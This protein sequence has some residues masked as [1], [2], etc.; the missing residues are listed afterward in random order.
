MF[1]SSGGDDKALISKQTCMN[2]KLSLE[3]LL[4]TETDWLKMWHEARKQERKIRGL[5]VDY[6]KRAERRREFY[7]KI[8]RNGNLLR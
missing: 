8:V 4:L 3:L 2:S 5:M 1:S 7:E 6:K